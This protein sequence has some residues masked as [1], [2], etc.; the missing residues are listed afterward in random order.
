VAGRDVLLR[1]KDDNPD[2]KV[3]VASGYL[4]PELKSEADRAGVKHFL[5]K[6]YTPDEAVRTLQSMI[7]EKPTAESEAR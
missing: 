3:I 6:P 4:E 2:L 7:E 1:L 5:H